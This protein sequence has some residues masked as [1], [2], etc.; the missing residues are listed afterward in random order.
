MDKVRRF[1]NS[2][3]VQNLQALQQQ[4]PHI[5][6]SRAYVR[7][8]LVVLF[9]VSLTAIVVANDPKKK[10]RAYHQGLYDGPSACKNS[11]SYRCDECIT[12]AI[13]G[14]KPAPNPESEA[15]SWD[16]KKDAVNFGLNNAQCDVAFTGLFHAIDDSVAAASTTRNTTADMESD[17][18]MPGSI[19][20]VV[21]DGQLYIHS[22]TPHKKDKNAFRAR[23]IALLSSLHRALSASPTPHLIPNIEFTMTV[24]NS[25]FN[26]Y[27]ERPNRPIWAFARR[28]EDDK[29][30]LMPDFGSWSADELHIS[31]YTESRLRIEDVEGQY[32]NHWK[33]KFQ[34]L[35]WR[36]EV[37]E[38]EKLRGDLMRATD[39]KEWSDVQALDSHAGAHNSD[40]AIEDYCRHMFL[41]VAEGQSYSGR[42]RYLQNC[43]SVII[44]HKAQW[45]TPLTHLMVAQGA[46]QNF[47]QVERD[48]SDLSVQMVKLRTNLDMAEK[49][50][51]RSREVFGERY[52]T[53]AA[54][55]CYWRR[56]VDGWAKVTE[57][58][59]I[60]EE[61]MRRRWRG[62]PFETWLI[63][64]FGSKEWWRTQY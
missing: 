39:R 57:P 50:A 31:S 10:L 56:L 46:Q 53:P 7:Y 32:K 21:Q 36:G 20:A 30:W 15:W 33:Q 4:L 61:D 18:K 41:A 2:P 24:Q 63:I 23:T 9:A 25:A 60:Y 43:R 42:I 58:Y 11:V 14:S 19:R 3:A 51:D 8:L 48:W 37:Y 1:A 62:I 52:N 5:L 59:E 44:A 55:A 13:K 34:N 16:W 22:V 45:I 26:A 40:H 6:K 17:M 49:I 64:G 54:E 47:V 12:C 38:A 28:Q 35:F 27:R 29:V